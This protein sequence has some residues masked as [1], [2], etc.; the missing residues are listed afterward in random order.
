MEK[1]SNIDKFFQK[2]KEQFIFIGDKLNLFIPKRYQA[3]EGMLEVGDE[4]KTLG[5]FRMEINN[6]YWTYFHCLI[7]MDIN[8]T[9]LENHNKNGREY[10]KVTLTAGDI[11]MKNRTFVKNSELLRNFYTE[12]VTRG[13]FPMEM[14]FPEIIG[15]FDNA[16]RLCGAKIPIDHSIPEVIMS[17]LI[18]EE[19]DRIKFLR[20]KENI[21]QD[22]P[23]SIVPLSNVSRAPTTTT[24]SIVG[25]RSADGML[26]SLVTERENEG[27]VENILR[28]KYTKDQ[29]PSA[30]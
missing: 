11:F 27:V 22:E 24:S 10:F 20:H 5:S 15:I 14:S 4:I 30:F 16:D 17:H 6:K 29:N 18:R 12:I 21:K 9:N 28:N 1:I 25:S 7:M 13:H 2:T 3:Y 23:Y 8:Y 26:A 19:D